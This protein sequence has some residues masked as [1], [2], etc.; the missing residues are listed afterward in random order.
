MRL[1]AAARIN[2]EIPASRVARR[3]KAIAH[4]G[5][6]IARLESSHGGHRY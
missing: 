4:R 6:L 5:K 2:L 3:V 1:P